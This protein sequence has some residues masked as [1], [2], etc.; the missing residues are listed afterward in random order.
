MR[1]GEVSAIACVNETAG[2]R[3][4]RWL[5]GKGL[6][7]PGDVS[8]TGFH[9]PVLRDPAQ[10][11]LTSVVASYEGIGAAALRRLLYRVQ[12]PAEASRTILFPCSLCHGKSTGRAGSEP[13]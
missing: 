9:R 6:R 4:H 2:W 7:V 3:L 1:A 10:P 5:T 11:D 8:I 13:A 12:N